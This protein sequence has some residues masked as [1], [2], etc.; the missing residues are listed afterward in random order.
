[1]SWV[2]RE[3]RRRAAEGQED[4]R[5]DSRQSCSTDII[6]NRLTT[7]LESM[8]PHIAL[9]CGSN[10][11]YLAERVGTITLD[12]ESQTFPVQC[13]Y[14]TSAQ[15]WAMAALAVPVSLLIVPRPGERSVCLHSYSLSHRAACPVT[16]GHRRLHQSPSSLIG[17]NFLTC[18]TIRYS[19]LDTLDSVS[20]VP[21]VGPI[22]R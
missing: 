2:K 15:V 21:R 20:P 11:I 22:R 19:G 5:T 18:M 3:E 8:E 10:V 4:D 6:Y 7:S 12:T 16:Y 17:N 9:H 14:L 13:M 1:M